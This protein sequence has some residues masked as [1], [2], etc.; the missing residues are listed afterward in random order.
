MDEKLTE[1]NSVAGTSAPQGEIEM[2]DEN[3]R[4]D[5]G[6][7][8]I[9]DGRRIDLHNNFLFDGLDYSVKDGAVSLSWRRSQGQWVDEI[10][11]PR[12]K[13]VFTNVGLL[14]MEASLGP[15][16]SGPTTLEF[17]G[18]LNAADEGVMNGFL[19]RNEVSESYHFIFAFEGGLAIK[20]GASA[21]YV[22]TGP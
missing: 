14:R 19:E 9:W 4:F 16:P 18:Y 15:E 13:I 12:F 5:A 17:A 21:G 3:F 7:A 10:D 22:D 11:P 6:Y 20:I 1:G 2:I 8:L